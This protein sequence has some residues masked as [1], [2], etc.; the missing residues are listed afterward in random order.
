MQIEPKFEDIWRVWHKYL[1]EWTRDRAPKLIVILILAFIFTRLLGMI[2]RRV[3][4]FSEKRSPDSAARTQQV[5]TVVG[6][7]HSAGVLLIVFFASM[8]VLKEVFNINIEPLLASAGI[9]GLAVGFGSQTLVKDVINGFFILLENQ[10]QV[11]DNIRTAGVSGKVEEITMRRTTLRDNDG[12]LHVVP[13]GAMQVV[14]NM[15][16]DWAQ[17]SLHVAVDYSE[18]SD[19]VLELLQKVARE[20]NEDAG[21]ALDVVSEPQ[22]PGIDRVRGQEVDYVMLVK[23]RPGRQDT[24]ARELRRRIKACFE[25]NKVK[26]GAP[27]LAYSIQPHGEKR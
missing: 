11:G 21:F 4:A 12:T 5:R 7:L 9:A 15:T 22:V 18:N 8:S 25:E 16:R 14:S 10:F 26:A 2:T 6:A 13:N 1:V 24:V 27:G 23:V 17:V 3:V 19:R 20:F